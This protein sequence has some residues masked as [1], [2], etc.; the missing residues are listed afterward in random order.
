MSKRSPSEHK[1]LIFV[2]PKIIFPLPGGNYR[3]S[4]EY[5]RSHKRKSELHSGQSELGSAEAKQKKVNCVG[6][7]HSDSGELSH[8]ANRKFSL[9][10]F[11]PSESVFI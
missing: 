11:A 8:F 5:L 9:K 2:R 10:I 1:T 7:L 4:G 3:R 6:R